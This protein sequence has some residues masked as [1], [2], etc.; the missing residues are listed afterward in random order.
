MEENFDGI[1]E[2]ENLLFIKMNQHMKNYQLFTEDLITKQMAKSALK[3]IQK[4]ISDKAKLIG[5][6]GKGKTTSM[7]DIDILIPFMKFDT[8]LKNKL[9]NLLNAKSVTNTDWGGW[10]FTGTDF[11]DVDIFYTTKDFD[12]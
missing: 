8:E 9:K 12:Y 11:G 1:Q 5:G 4:E 2:E 3:L 7:H 6:F 10:Y